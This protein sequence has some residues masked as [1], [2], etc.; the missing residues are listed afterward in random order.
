MICLHVQRVKCTRERKGK[1]KLCMSTNV[2][3]GAVWYILIKV[4]R[5][6][7]VRKNSENVSAVILPLAWTKTTKDVWLCISKEEK[8]TSFVHFYVQ[9]YLLFI[10]ANY[11]KLIGSDAH[12]ELMLVFLTVSL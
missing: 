6:C 10:S 7:S 8:S 4:K 12:E 3:V 1:K 2:G 5:I 11:V 9:Y